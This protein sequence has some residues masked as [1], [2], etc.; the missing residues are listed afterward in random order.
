[1]TSTAPEPRPDRR[2]A[3]APVAL[4]TGASL[5]L[6]LATTR[7]LVRHGWHVVADAR[8]GTRLAAALADL[9]AAVTTLPGD[10][11]DPRHRED[12]VAAVRDLGRLDLLVANASTLGP[13]PLPALADLSP[14]AFAR[15]LAVNTVAPLAL[16]Q[17][18][19]PLL[20]SSGGSLV[21]VSSDAAV[22]AY[23]GW[24]GYG[25]SKAALDHVAAVLGVENPT[26]AV[27]AVDPGDMATA[28][29]ARAVP[30]AD[31]TEL[32]DPADVAGALHELVRRRPPSGRHRLA[33]VRPGQPTTGPAHAAATGPAH[34]AAPE[35]AHAAATDP[36]HAA[37]S[38]TARPARVRG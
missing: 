33:D 35:P 32:A 3:A 19:L 24:G 14:A 11:A 6:G 10:V 15:V 36:A 9:G 20:R 5:G 27:Y 18:L 21:T 13:V 38:E 26:V 34:D 7:L 31:P 30:D 12:L 8:D 23:P 37:A 28:M 29:H 2:S 4:V 16:A 25:A 22:E 17:A 1:M